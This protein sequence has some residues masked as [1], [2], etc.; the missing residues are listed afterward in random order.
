MANKT[1]Q[2]SASVND[3]IA[4][5]Q[6]EEKRTDCIAID[7]LM[8]KITGFKPAMWG[9]SIV[10][11]DT[12]HYKYASGREG[13][14]MKVGFSPRAQNITLYIMPGF[15]DYD[16][17]LQKLGK[18]KLGKSC[19]YIKRLSDIDQDV[20]AELISQSYQYMCAKYD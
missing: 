18:H 8:Q 15:S 16:S 19:L 4:G 10:G 7:E 1:V 20:L 12:Y 14:Y 9:P 17:L 6:D 3:F 11:Y 13:D 5:V 2:N